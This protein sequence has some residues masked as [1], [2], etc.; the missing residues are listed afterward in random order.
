MKQRSSTHV[1]V[2]AISGIFLFSACDE[3]EPND[4][5]TTR[6]PAP[7]QA[8]K[9]PQPPNETSQPSTRPERVL[10]EA[11][12][13]PLD[14][15]DPALEG[16]RVIVKG[17]IVPPSPV[18]D[19]ETGMMHMGSF[20]REVEVFAWSRLRR[21]SQNRRYAVFW[22][23]S[24]IPPRKIDPEKTTSVAP[25]TDDPLKLPFKSK[26]FWQQQHYT[27][28]AYKISPSH[29]DRKNN[30]PKSA[31]RN[32]RTRRL[33]LSQLQKNERLLE[34]FPDAE[35]RENV[36]YLYGYRQRPRYGD[37]RITYTGKRAP[38][39]GPSIV[40]GYQKGDMLDHGKPFESDF[41]LR[42]DEEAVARYG[43]II[44][45]TNTLSN[46]RAY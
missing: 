36:L 30:K 22:T 25:L 42:R 44:N 9:T 7:T 24:P 43:L 23:T 4:S 5:S 12:E 16:K 27:I 34:D 45:G 6:A 2:L 40:E 31:F 10:D 15:I 1:L 3:V 18:V 46:E 20:R 14:R 33:D 32:N 19:E 26:S 17:T 28:G 8:R 39:V 21:P 29:F 41:K 38:H 13:A 35:F 37:I 11:I